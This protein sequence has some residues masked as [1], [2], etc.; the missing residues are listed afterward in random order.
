M[1]LAPVPRSRHLAGFGSMT[2]PPHF[3]V[4]GWACQPN[5]ARQETVVWLRHR[6]FSP[7][8]PGG[9]TG[10]KRKK[11]IGGRGLAL[12]SGRAADLPFSVPHWR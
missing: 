9:G 12:S 8:A 7:S 3:R 11:G 5:P 4:G 6:S 2:G 10:E 1:A